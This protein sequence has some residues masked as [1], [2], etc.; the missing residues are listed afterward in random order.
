MAVYGATRIEMRKKLAMLV[1][2]SKSNPPDR[3]FWHDALKPHLVA[4]IAV[5]M[6]PEAGTPLE[7]SRKSEHADK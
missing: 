6:E 3:L 4:L 7:G 5:V 1:F 2:A